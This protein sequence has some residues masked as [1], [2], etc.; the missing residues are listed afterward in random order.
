MFEHPALVL[1]VLLMET[2]LSEDVCFDPVSCIRL[3]FLHAV[4]SA[5]NVQ[6]SSNNRI[7]SEVIGIID[8]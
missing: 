4:F 1:T 7:L 2:L 8:L 3:V 6:S 5:G